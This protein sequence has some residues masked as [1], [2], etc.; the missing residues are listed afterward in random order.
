MT[1]FRKSFF[2]AI[3]EHFITKYTLCKKKND[4]FELKVSSWEFFVLVFAVNDTEVQFAIVKPNPSVSIAGEIT[5][6]KT[7]YYHQP[8]TQISLYSVR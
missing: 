5:F 4:P 6:S 2:L 1:P 8:V 7:K 3:A